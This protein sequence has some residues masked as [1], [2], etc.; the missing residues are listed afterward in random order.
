MSY[1]F[2]NS[3]IENRDLEYGSTSADGVNHDADLNKNLA[4]VAEDE[5][6]KNHNRDLNT[7]LA[8]E[9]ADKDEGRLPNIRNMLHCRIP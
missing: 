6:G 8:S 2:F 3:G 4:C 1:L 9:Y 5:D 7:G